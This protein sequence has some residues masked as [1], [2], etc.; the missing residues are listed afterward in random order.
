MPPP[1]YAGLVPFDKRRHAGLGVRPHAARFAARL[2][3]IQVALAE[4]TAVARA[5]PIVFGRDERDR[6]HPLIV[7]GVEPGRNLFVDAAG[8]WRRDEYCPAYVRR[9]P[10][11]TVTVRDGNGPERALVCVDETGLS[12]APP[13]LF[14]TAGRPTPRWREVQRFIEET[15][16]ARMATDAFCAG[17]VELDLLEEF[18]ADFNP[19]LGARQRLAGMQRVGSARIARLPDATLA[20]LVRAGTLAAIHAH[21]LSLENFQRLLTAYGGA[22]NAA[23]GGHS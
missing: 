22:S 7:T 11:C 18:A 16:A 2:P 21:L 10:F 13:H 19:A 15:A 8:D 4:F 12:E 20:S 9:Y 3:A 5:Y 17:L 6:V 14:D 1:G 23:G